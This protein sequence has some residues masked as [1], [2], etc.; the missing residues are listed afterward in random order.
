MRDLAGTPKGRLPKL[1]KDLA[2]KD[3]QEVKD[4]VHVK[5]LPRDGELCAL[6]RSL[7]RRGNESAMRCTKLKAY[8][9]R[10]KELRKRDKLTRDDLLPAPPPPEIRKPKPVVAAF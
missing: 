6:A 8:R 9:A 1:E 3:W 7:P 4:D 2:T 5:L 10:L